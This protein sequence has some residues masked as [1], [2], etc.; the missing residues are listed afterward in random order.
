MR[1][2]GGESVQIGWCAGC[3]APVWDN[4]CYLRDGDEMIHAEGVG[5]RATLCDGSGRR[6]NVSCLLLYVQEVCLEEEVIDALRLR[7]CGRGEGQ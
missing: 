7:R 5:G 1:R 3:G 2:D 4:E 6:V